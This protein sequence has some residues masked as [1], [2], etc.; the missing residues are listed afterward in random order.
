MNWR[1]VPWCDYVSAN[2]C[3]LL[4]VPPFG[5]AQGH[6]VNGA[7]KVRAVD[8]FSWSCRSGGKKRRRS[9]MKSSSVNGHYEPDTV[10]RHDHLD[11]LLGSMRFHHEL[12]SQVQRGPCPWRPMPSHCVPRTCRHEGR[13]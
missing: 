6:T 5:I 7:V 4:L 1:L 2:A 13:Y 11:D 8:I 9:E 12:S 10:M 3:Q